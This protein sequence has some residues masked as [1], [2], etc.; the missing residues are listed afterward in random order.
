MLSFI[1][2]CMRHAT[3]LQ[4]I[5]AFVKYYNRKKE[6]KNKLLFCPN[7]VGENLM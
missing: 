4:L 2:P 6:L 7:A 1:T 3:I 5:N